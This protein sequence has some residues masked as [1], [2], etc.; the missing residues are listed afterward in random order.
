MAVGE[1]NVIEL[2][3]PDVPNH[4]LRAVT[5]T[6]PELVLHEGGVLVG[7]ALTTE[8][9][10]ES[11]L[12]FWLANP[13]IPA[14]NVCSTLENFMPTND[15][16]RGLLK[17]ARFLTNEGSRQRAMGLIA[18]GDPWLGKTHVSVGIAKAIALKDELGKVTYLNAATSD[19]HI[20]TKVDDY[21]EMA[22]EGRGTVIL[23][24]VNSAYGS[25]AT[26]LRA[27]ISAIHDV[28]GRLFITSNA[29]DIDQFL[30][31][32]LKDVSDRDGIEFARL[33]D[34]AKGILLPLKLMGQSYRENTRQNPW[35]DFMANEEP[36]KSGEDD[37]KGLGN[38]ARELGDGPRE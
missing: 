26:G 17:A 12:N 1:T 38:R 23:D 25:G 8:E 6:H 36:N 29:Q 30:A 21:R 28:G 11:D 4:V 13:K 33:M 27:A 5:V 34:R 7:C 37:A 35:I 22:A 3:R 20:P 14:E 18:F 19:G 31:S 2:A 24:D 32:A 10:I 15:T 9:Q 16:Q